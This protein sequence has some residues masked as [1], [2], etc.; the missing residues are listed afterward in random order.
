MINRS[1]SGFTIVEMLMV[2][3][4]LAV[5]TGIVGT[6][7]SSAIRQARNRRTTALRQLVEVGIATYYA[8]K[9]WWPPKG[10]KLD[11]WSQNGVDQGDKN[12]AEAESRSGRQRKAL[13]RLEDNDY[14]RLMSE[15]VSVSVK[16]S[17]AVPVMD[18][19]GLIVAPSSAASR[20]TTYGQEFRDAIKK[21]RKHGSTL[22]LSEMAFGYQES[23]RGYFRRF[24]IFYNEESDSVSVDTQ[25]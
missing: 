6:A 4:V 3:A 23:S 10:G 17:G 13:P 12:R 24:H 20:K 14:D 15:I 8:Q 19:M 2:V 21:K 16:G 22:T 25:P 7:A 11:K 5:L 18:P 9:G 1:K